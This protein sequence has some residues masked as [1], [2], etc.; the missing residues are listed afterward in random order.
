[1]STISRV[2]AREVLDSRGKPTVEAE[3]H[4][5]SGAMGSAIVP[6]GA[7]TGTAEACELRDGDPNR[8]DGQGV[9]Q[10]VRNVNE[11][12][13]PA[14]SGQRVDQQAEIDGLMI[15][16]DGTP[17]KS[18]LGANAIL[19][20]SLAVAQAAALSNREPL[21][22]YLERQFREY[23]EVVLP[24]MPALKRLKC[25]V[26]KWSTWLTRVESVVSANHQARMPLPMTNM[27]SGGK[28]AGGNLDFQ[29]ILIQPN[30]APDYRTGL[31]WIVRIYRRL[32]E[33]LNKAGYE[34]YLVGDEGG[35]G[36]RL[37]GNREAVEFV[38]RAIEAAGLQ[39]REQVTIAIDVA[40][41]HFYRDGLYHLA[42][43][44]GRKLSSSEMISRL[45]EWVDEFPITSIEDGLAEEDWSGWTELTS[46]LGSR[47]HLVGDDL[48]ATNY[49]R[50]G[51]GIV[52]HAGN[53]VLIK[54]NQIGTLTET[55]IAV[56][57]A[58]RAGFATVVS[59]RSG[60]SED[61]FMSDLAVAVAADRI[62]V[63]S[64]ARSERLAKYNRLLRIEEQLK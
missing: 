1:M 36:P 52:Q 7:S 4:L 58:K 25:D 45:E 41:T 51:Q 11:I 37:P 55:L 42:A 2:F 17:N 62:K 60:E 61:T 49:D 54:M 9:L 3:V 13:A 64:I 33:L 35:Y 50:I 38:V 59:A 48:F 27:I 53:A 24:I 32:G 12:I 26:E 29:D 43:E 63:G 15:E 21:F 14:L 40:S 16:L 5:S 22:V 20:V 23:Q 31:E 30:G 18:K 56:D 19:S 6:S 44:K 28:H 46:K 57:L 10:A 34:G 47:C 8:Y 39:P